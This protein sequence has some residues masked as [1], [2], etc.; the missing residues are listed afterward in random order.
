MLLCG[1]TLQ[2]EGLFSP[3]LPSAPFGSAASNRNIVFKVNKFQTKT[4]SPHGVL[5]R[6]ST[7]NLKGIVQMEK[8]V[9]EVV[10]GFSRV[11][12]KL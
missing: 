3:V 9:L 1:F 10:D 6:I 4:F 7:Y 5:K 2:F 11:F 12:S 8:V